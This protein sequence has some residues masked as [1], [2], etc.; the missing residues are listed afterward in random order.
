[1]KAI[2]SSLS[3]PEIAASLAECWRVLESHIMLA[4]E[5]FCKTDF[6]LGLYGEAKCLDAEWG[7]TKQKYL[8]PFDLAFESA[9]INRGFA[10]SASGRDPSQYIDGLTANYA[11]LKRRVD[12][13]FADD[14]QRAKAHGDALHHVALVDVRSFLTGAARH[15]AVVH[16]SL[17]RKLESVL[18]A[19][20]R[21]N[22]RIEFDTTG[23]ILDANDNV[24]RLFGYTHAEFVG[25][26]HRRICND[27]TASSP[28]YAAF[29]KDLSN[30]SFKSGEYQ[31]LTK[32]CLDVTIQA[33]YNP[34]IDSEEKVVRIVKLGTDVTRVRAAE[35]SDADHVRNMHIIAERHRSELEQIIGKVGKIV[36]TIDAISRQT[37]LLALNAAIEAARVGGIGQG[38][39]VVASEVKRL[40]GCSKEAAEQ[41]R[42]LILSGGSL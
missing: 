42:A 39:A 38:F 40:S 11:D 29:W 10:Y 25:L 15:D 17:Q 37:G 14:L 24:L 35:K 34:I 26:H 22:L 12:L 41:A 30:G 33:S 3:N 27:Q 8:G 20:D 13:A 23:T 1:M 6:A 2:F 7:F 32:D 16:D 31:R 5:Q 36:D 21:S 4:T 28:E 9:M 19:F 18:S